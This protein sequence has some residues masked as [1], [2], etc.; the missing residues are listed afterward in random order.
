MTNDKLITLEAAVNLRKGIKRLVFTNGHFDLIHTGHVDYLQQ[1]RA[2][3]DALFLGLNSDSSTRTLK[4]PKRP[5][6]AD[7]DRAFVLAALSCI[8]A[9]IIFNDLTAHKLIE[10][11]RPMVYVKGGDYIVDSNK[12]GWFYQ[13]PLW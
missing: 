1:A 13:K 8:E 12:K 5:L 10:A 4:G 11:L 2:L 6:V 3:G 9:I 7:I